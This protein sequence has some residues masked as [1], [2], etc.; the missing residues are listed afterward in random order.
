MKRTSKYPT[1][2]NRSYAKEG[3]ITTNAMNYASANKQ[4]RR[5]Q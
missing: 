4:T 3:I 1:P 5:A 2:Q